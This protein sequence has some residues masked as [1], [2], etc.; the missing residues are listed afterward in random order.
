MCPGLVKS[1]HCKCF[2]HENYGDWKLRG[3]CRDP[4]VFMVKTFSVSKLACLKKNVQIGPFSCPTQKVYFDDLDS[5]TK[6]ESV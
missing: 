3:P 5:K 4:V 6:V 1:L 2:D